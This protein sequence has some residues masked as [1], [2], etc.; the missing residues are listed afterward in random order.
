MMGFTG[1]LVFLFP[2]FGW[3]L[4]WTLPLILLLGWARVT[5]GAHTIAQVIAGAAAGILLTL[6]QAWVIL[7][8]LLPVMQ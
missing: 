1:P 4:L 6:A 3:Q 5:L 2:L 8:I 7:E